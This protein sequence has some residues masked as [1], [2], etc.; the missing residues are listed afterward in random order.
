[1]PS[2]SK[3]RLISDGRIESRGH[4][5]GVLRN[6]RHDASSPTPAFPQA[7]STAPDFLSFSPTLAERGGERHNSK[8]VASG[9]HAGKELRHGQGT[10]QKTQPQLEQCPSGQGA[11]RLPSPPPAML[12]LRAKL[13]SWS[14][15]AARVPAITS[16]SSQKEE[17][18]RK[19][20]SLGTLPGGFA[21][22]DYLPLI[23]LSL[24]RAPG[25]PGRRWGRDLY[26]R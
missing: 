12:G 14:K 24:N 16:R 10:W 22:H 21:G 19:G 1:M 20:T 4:I 8:S 15:A 6:C 9:V 2:A 5:Q 25:A 26:P 13:G 11:R 3:G 23:V 7:P 18:V 17:K